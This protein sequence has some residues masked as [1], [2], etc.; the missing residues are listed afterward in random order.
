M[1]E[2]FRAHVSLVNLKGK[3]T[4]VPCYDHT[5]PE[6]ESAAMCGQGRLN[7]Y[8]PKGVPVEYLE[9]SCAVFQFNA[10]RGEWERYIVVAGLI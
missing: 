8:I 2:I 1:S 6:P 9:A 10:K 3:R 4:I 7:M 5:H